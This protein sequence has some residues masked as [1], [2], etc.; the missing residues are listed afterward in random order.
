MWLVRLALN[1][2]YTFVIMSCLIV[3]L[4]GVSIQTM[5]VDVFPYIDLPVLSVIFNYGGISSEE[6][7]LLRGIC[8]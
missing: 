8:G 2:P 6:M 4:G 7:W 3:L 5:P 1:R